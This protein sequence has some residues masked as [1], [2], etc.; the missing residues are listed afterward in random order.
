M[1]TP[2]SLPILLSVVFFDFE[3]LQLCSSEALRFSFSPF[4]PKTGMTGNG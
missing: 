3:F 1:L 4:L 2:F